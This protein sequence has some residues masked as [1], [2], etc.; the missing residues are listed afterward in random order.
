MNVTFRLSWEAV[1][2]A[3]SYYLTSLAATGTGETVISDTLTDTY[4]DA[5]IDE[6]S[7]VVYMVRAYN[8]ASYGPPTTIIYKAPTTL[9]SM[10]TK[11]RIM[12]NDNRATGTPKFA[13]TE[14]NMYIQQ[15][16]DNYSALFP[17]TKLISV[18]LTNGVHTY[19][20]PSDIQRATEVY[21]LDATGNKFY[22]KDKPYKSGETVL[23]DVSGLYKLGVERVPSSTRYY[24]GHYS[25]YNGYI[26]IDFSPESS[27]YLHVH[28]DGKYQLPVVDGVRIDIPIEDEELTLL[29]AAGLATVR[30]LGQDANLQRWDQSSGRRD[31][32][33]LTQPYNSY[34]KQYQE[35]IKDR[36]GKPRIM[37]RVRI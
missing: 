8:G 35:R 13:D 18:A 2:G 11:L 12:L 32:N 19:G 3:L 14:L 21:Y 31:D 20:L 33:P 28:Y 9:S 25:I 7:D 24:N 26:T 15:S 16:I 30:V 23:E 10:R 36:M 22:L 5:S 29:Y 4:Y 27:T 34:M 1:D 17:K 6:L 37:S